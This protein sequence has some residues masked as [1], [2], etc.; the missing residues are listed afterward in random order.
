MTLEKT[1]SWPQAAPDE[2]L[3]F[4]GVYSNLPA[5]EALKQQAEV[6]GIP[7]AAC[8]CTGDVAAYGASPAACYSLL[9]DWGVHAIRGN[10]EDQLLSGEEDC[11]CNFEEGSTCDLLSK[12]WFPFVQQRIEQ[13]HLAFME[14]MPQLLRWSWQGYRVVLLHGGYPDQSAFLFRSSPAEEKASLLRLLGADILIAGH[15]GLPFYEKLENG[16]WINPGVIGMPANDGGTHTWYARLKAQ[17]TGIELAF[18]R[19][20][21][22]HLEAQAA[23]RAACLPEAYALTLSTGIWDNC[24]I[25]PEAETQQQGLPIP[26]PEGFFPVLSS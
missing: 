7:A 1:L 15:C 22:P 18:E 5:L 10:V 3:L 25:L 9:E 26:L 21:Y 19:L 16:L 12:R 20:H 6:L 8:F 13:R 2:L 14:R 24:D 23:M 4:G 17:K 11:G